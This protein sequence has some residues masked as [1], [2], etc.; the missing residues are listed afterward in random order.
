MSQKLRETLLIGMLALCACLATTTRALAEEITVDEIIQRLLASEARMDVAINDVTVETELVERRHNGD[1]SI[2]EE[3]VYSK[4]VYFARHEDSA[5]RSHVYEQF[6]SY[7]KNGDPQDPEKLEKEVKSK[8]EKQKKGRGQD[9]AK[10]ITDVFLE[11][12][13]EFYEIEFIGTLDSAIEGYSC[14]HVRVR[15]RNHDYD[16]KDRI[17]A[18]FYIDTLSFRP[19]YVTFKPAKLSGNLMFKFKELNMQLLY[20]NYGEDVWLPK[21]FYLKAKAKAG[22]FF[23]VRFTVT[24]HFDEPV[25]NSSLP[26]ELFD[27]QI[28]LY[29]PQ[30]LSSA[31]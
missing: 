7:H 31:E 24:E 29:G 17:N 18:D 15:A 12:Y 4:V 27:E 13:R 10:M 19:V 25:F 2:K 3:K 1:D 30:E 26:V 8:I 16:L 23:T 21:R 28:G 14:Y 6:L 22:L 11:K 20:A 9:K 5:R